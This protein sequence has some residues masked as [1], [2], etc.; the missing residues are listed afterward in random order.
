MRLRN[1]G[2]PMVCLANAGDPRNPRGGRIAS[3]DLP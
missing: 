3:G 1:N 2:Q